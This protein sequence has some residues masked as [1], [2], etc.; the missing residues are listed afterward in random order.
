MTVRI[1]LDASLT[2]V[3]GSVTVTGGTLPRDNA[4]EKGQARDRDRERLRSRRITQE[5]VA[6]R[7][8]VD[9]TYVC[10]YL[11]GRRSPKKDRI[12]RAI[13]ALCAAHDRQAS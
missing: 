11:A 3:R 5:Q 12:Q 10:H 1:L 6:A 8:Q 9:R 7:A 4:T 13:D 2:F